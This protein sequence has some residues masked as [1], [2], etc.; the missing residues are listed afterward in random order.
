MIKRKFGWI[1]MK[2][3]MPSQPG[4][5]LIFVPTADK[6]NPYIGVANWHPEDKRWTMI[7]TAFAEN[8]AYWSE[9]PLPGK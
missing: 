5:H 9:I 8:V 4:K 1:D 2:K 6:K 7:L 3:K